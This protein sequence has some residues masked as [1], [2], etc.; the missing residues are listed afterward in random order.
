[1]NVPTM[2]NA[3]RGQLLTDAMKSGMVRDAIS[4]MTDRSA[5]RAPK[6]RMRAR[7]TAY[8]DQYLVWGN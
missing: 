8:K 2:A 7:G 4:N 3:Q 5:V 6:V 1:M